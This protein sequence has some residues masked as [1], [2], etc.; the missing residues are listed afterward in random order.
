MT[1]NRIYGDVYEPD[2]LALRISVFWWGKGSRKSWG[3]KRESFETI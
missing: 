1:L 3:K 2:L